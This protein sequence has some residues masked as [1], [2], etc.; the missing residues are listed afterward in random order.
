MFDPTRSSLLR[1]DPNKKPGPQQWIRFY[2]LTNS[3]INPV[4]NLAP[5]H[6]QVLYKIQLVLFKYPMPIFNLFLTG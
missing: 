4:R 6:I 1:P 2:F 3:G 5:M